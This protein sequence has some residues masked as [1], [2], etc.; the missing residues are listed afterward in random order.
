MGWLVKH[1]QEHPGGRKSFR[2]QYPPHLRP[3][4]SG[5]QLRVS[6]GRPDSPDFHE[7][8]AKAARQWE[9]DVAVAERKLA[10]SF[11]QL[12][13]ELTAYLAHAWLKSALEIDE[14]VRWTDRP[15]ARKLEARSVMLEEI[16][17][18]LQNALALRAVGDIA[19]I[20]ADWGEAAASH[21]ADMG[22]LLDPNSEAFP[23]Y[24][25]M[26]HDA[27]IEAWRATLKRLEGEEVPTPAEPEPPAAPAKAVKKRAAEV[28][29]VPTFEAY[30][31]AQGVSDGVRREWLKY[32][33]YLI[34]FVGHD[35][36]QRLTRG[37]VVAW[38]DHLLETPTR[39]GAARKPVTVRDKYI[40]AL[41][42]TL[43]W[44]KEEKRLEENVAAD[45]RVRIP[46]EAKVRDKD[47][48]I[49][50]AKAILEA[51]LVAPTEPRRV[52]RRL[53]GISYAAMG[54]SSSMA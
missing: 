22:F 46:K 10:G 5:T 13:P 3:Y 37:D 33:Q 8:Y 25:R 9:D 32:I 31:E 15:T 43:A 23:A 53:F 29:L 6:L 34:G 1:I 44:A 19:A 20:V 21:A 11:D 42:C 16:E 38:R 35:D 18:D 39:T 47:F 41:R 17:A 51:S 27:Q 45:V 4:L 50:E 52:C 30:A 48:T 49:D 54:T 40:T 7:R 28:L 26:L 12:T 14:E 24:V 2:R 36:A